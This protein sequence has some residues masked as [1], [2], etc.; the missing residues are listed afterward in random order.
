[1]PPPS[2][3]A[4]EETVERGRRWRTKRDLFSLLLSPASSLKSFLRQTLC[5]MDATPLPS[6]DE[7]RERRAWLGLVMFAIDWEVG[8]R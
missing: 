4:T 6:G 5:M 8:E 2:A 3:A 1:M 7:G